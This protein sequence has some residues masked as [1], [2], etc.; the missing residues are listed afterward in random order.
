MNQNE[1]ILFSIAA[2]AALAFMA[3][4]QDDV[5]EEIVVTSQYRGNF[6]DLTDAQREASIASKLGIYAGQNE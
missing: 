4:R 6:A 3:R 5:L 2:L 1:I